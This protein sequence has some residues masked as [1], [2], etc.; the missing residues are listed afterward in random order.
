MNIPNHDQCNLTIPAILLPCRG[1]FHLILCTYKCR[2]RK[3]LVLCISVRH[4]QGVRL[5]PN[6]NNT[7]NQSQP[8]V[9]LKRLVVLVLAGL[10]I[11]NLYQVRINKFSFINKFWTILS[12]FKASSKFFDGLLGTVIEYE[13]PSEIQAPSVSICPVEREW[14]SGEKVYVYAWSYIKLCYC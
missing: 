2:I 1:G 4:L 13:S 6:L 14:L 5:S 12:W 11:R 3:R 7:M 9:V 8:S 10:L